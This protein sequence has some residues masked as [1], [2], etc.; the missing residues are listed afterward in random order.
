MT[1]LAPSLTAEYIIA[2]LEWPGWRECVE[3]WHQ[4]ASQRWPEIVIKHQDILLAYQQGLHESNESNEASADIL[5]T[6]HDDLRILEPDWDRRVLAEFA[7]P[8]VALVGFAGATGHCHPQMYSHPYHHSSMGR[9]GFRSNLVNAEQHGARFAGCCNA[10]VL[11][12]MAFFVRRR[13]L[14][15][16]GGWPLSTPISYYMYME[17]LSC[18]VRRHGYR[19]RLVGVTV[20]HLDHRSTGLNPNLHPDFE[21]E[22]RFIFD[23]FRDVLPA[24]V[25]P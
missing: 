15:E 9:V 21:A 4:T 22:H 5:F 18:M 19:I 24:A 14:N 8:A 7:D 6:L 17:W 10:V 25:E 3:T 13:V 16:I 2:T 20:D 11:D 1:L 23:N 12:G